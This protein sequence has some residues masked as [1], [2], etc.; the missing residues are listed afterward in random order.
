MQRLVGVQQCSL[1]NFHAILLYSRLS[2][3]QDF[4][5]IGRISLAQLWG[6]K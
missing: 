5:N 3:I 6:Q 4:I 2:N 1:S